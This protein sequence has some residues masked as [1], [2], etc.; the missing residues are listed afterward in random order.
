MRPWLLGV[1]LVAVACSAP[2]PG[3]DAGVGG[4][5]AAGGGSSTGGGAAGGGQ[6]TGGGASADTTPPEVLATAPSDNAADVQN[7]TVLQVLFTEAMDPASVTLAVV[8]SVAVGQA[9]W[10]ADQTLATWT[11]QALL[12]LGASY[13]VTVNGADEAGNALAAPHT[14]SFTTAA[15]GDTT[16]PTLVSSSPAEG[17]TGVSTSTRLRLTFSEAMAPG[18]LSVSTAPAV[19]QNAATWSDGD[20]TATFASPAAPWAAGTTYVVTVSGQDLAGNPLAATSVGFTTSQAADTTPPALVAST[21]D[22]GATNVPTN[23]RLSLTFSEEMATNSVV[24]SSTPA[25]SLG[26][27]SWSNRN[28]TVTWPTPL[29]DWE[30]GRSYALRVAG[31]DVSGNA[32]VDGRLAFATATNRDVTPPTLVSSVPAAG[33]TGVARFSTLRLTF[34]EPMATLATQS[35][36]ALT[37]SSNSTVSCSWSWTS[38]DSVATCTPPLGWPLGTVTVRIGLGARDKAGNPIT[39]VVS[40]TFS[41]L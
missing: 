14:F 7:S 23:T 16:A 10:S 20:R 15:Q 13:S 38:T 41:T 29:A 33:A 22:A 32:L 17:A 21:P 18:A 35:A 30:E 37:S 4:G 8:P 28:T 24:V 3:D 26:L 12:A 1:C 27:P 34:S 31:T 39:Q 5:G 9:S 6:G 40:F 25:T 36:I 11:P 19:A 2:T